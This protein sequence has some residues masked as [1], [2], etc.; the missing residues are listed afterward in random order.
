MP[1]HAHTHMHV[2]F[3][4]EI[5]VHN[6]DNVAFDIPF[7]CTCI[8]NIFCSKWMPLKNDIILVSV[9]VFNFPILSLHFKR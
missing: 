6:L 3:Y 1:I 4:T 2:L 5:N 7:R 8:P 9:I